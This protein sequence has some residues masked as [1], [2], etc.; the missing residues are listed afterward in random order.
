MPGSWVDAVE[1]NEVLDS[2]RDEGAPFGGGVGQ[3][4]IIGERDQ[5]GVSD[6]RDH[7]VAPGP[8][9]LGNSVGEHFVKQDRPAH[10]LPGKQIALTPPCSLRSI[11]GGVRGVY[12]RI[13][14]LRIRRPVTH[15]GPQQPQRHAGIVADQGE[16]V[17]ARELRF[18]CMGGLDGTNHLPHV[19][20]ARQNSAPPSRAARG[21]H[22][23]GAPS[24]RAL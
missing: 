23:A 7:I 14:F 9:P 12:L 6:D 20:P 4:L 22:R 17:I 10:Q 24:G 13:D 19:G 11:F 2:G 1:R 16:D 21:R 15:R 5:R 8:K 18:A 3:D